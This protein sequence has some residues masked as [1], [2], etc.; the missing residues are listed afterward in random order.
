MKRHLLTL[1]LC[2]VLGAPVWAASEL[3]AIRSKAQVARTQVRTLRER[4]QALRGELNGLAGRIEA[5]KA[6]QQGKLTTGPELEQALRRSQEL[7]GELTGLAQAVAGAE[8]EAERAHLGLHAALSEE[9]T[10]VHTAWDAANN[11]EERS[12]LL[13]RMRQLRAEREAVRAALPASRVPALSRTEASDDPE[14]LLEQADAL[15]D[16]EDKVRQRL[17]SLKARIT[18]VREERALERRMNDFLGEES[19]F[20]DQDRRLRLR[21]DGDQKF[22]VEPSTPR[23]PTPVLAGDQ[24]EAAPPPGTVTGVPGGPRPGGTEDGNAS[25]FPAPAVPAASARASDNRPQV[26]ASRAQQLAAGDFDDLATL[27]AEAKRL[28]SLA[29]ELDSRAKALESKVR[30]LE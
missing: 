8:S 12:Q 13:S 1:M 4:Q 22:A 30:E 14:D 2:L 10:R 29:R 15:R 20:D 16:S 27:E 7:S 3:E 5:L 24:A 17:N 25:P 28:E 21:A 11:R 19:M 18:E 26:E 23:S 9:L 6:E